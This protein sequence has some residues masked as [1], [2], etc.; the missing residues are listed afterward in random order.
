MTRPVRILIVCA[1][2]RWN[3]AVRETLENV[4]P[5]ASFETAATIEALDRALA[6]GEV[7]LVLAAEPIAGT[8]PSC[9]ARMA[10]ARPKLPIIAVTPQPEDETT[11]EAGAWDA[12]SVASGPRLRH[13]VVRAL[14]QADERRIAEAVLR[15]R[16]RS[17]QLHSD[18]QAR[19]LA[20]RDA[21]VELTANPV[22]SGEDR[23]A[24]FRLITELQARTL[25]VARASIWQHTD[26]RSAILCLDLFEAAAGRHSSGMRMPAA[27]YPAYFAALT[28]TDVIV[29][30]QARTDPD[31]AELASGYLVPLD[32]SSM[33]DAA[34]RLRGRVEGVVCCEHVGPARTWTTDEASFA[35]AVASVVSLVLE[36]G[37]RQRVER[38]LRLLDAALNA[39]ANAMVITDRAGSIVWVNPAFT[40]LTGYASGEAVGR[41]HRDMVKSGAHDPAFYEGLWKVIGAGEVWRG[42]MINRRKDGT[43]YHE[44]QTI[45]PVKDAAGTIT[46]FIAIKRDLT[47]RRQLEAQF[48]QSQKMEVIGQLAGGVA[49]D[50]NNLL[51]VIH[52][53]ARFMTGDDGVVSDAQAGHVD[54]IIKAAER[55]AQLTRQLLAFSRRQVMET[56]T[57]D[58]NELTGHLGRMLQRLIGEHIEVRVPSGGERLLVTADR[59][60]LEQVLMNLAV[61]AKDAMPNGGVLEFRSSVVEAGA[62][63]P[64]PDA[65]KAG[66][67]VAISVADTGT[68]MSEEVRARVFEPFFTT[69][70]ADRGTG[71]GLSTVYGIVTQS[72]GH[73]LV[74]SQLGSGSTFT[75]CLPRTAQPS[76]ATAPKPAATP[77]PKAHGGDEVLL[78]V[79]DEEPV[80]MLAGTLLKRAGYSIVEAT[81]PS[82][83][84][85][86]FDR[87]EGGVDLLVTDMVMPGG[88]G[89]ELFL[90]L[91]EKRPGLRVVFMSGYPEDPALESILSR[92]G[93]TFLAKPF[94]AERL[95]RTVREVLDREP[96]PPAG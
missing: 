4:R 26:D 5:G 27:D 82:E 77:Q 62:D 58:V 96:L 24:A 92:P 70:P 83:A 88:T 46:H 75:V 20:Q 8:L 48:R 80:R 13:A 14:R 7:D 18:Q 63:G 29:A 68:G 44:A 90:A 64:L 45:T 81:K 23:A 17:K 87:L 71:L 49:H 1:D 39:A 43:R 69:K 11:I 91:V 38:E 21:L 67:Y 50:F 33:L 59:G 36:T 3:T 57:F 61:N 35:L 10:V 76:D 25:G 72:G 55:A 84:T 74:S 85:Q 78:L 19:Y 94:T 22:L 2:G 32:I 6:S 34:V 12:V 54:E 40:A 9:C 47:E 42:E 52:G 28:R 65:A 37:A 15:E 30:N 93:T 51:T 66:S 31:T 53:Y 56:S 95:M 41:N 89:A 16:D 60:Q 79:E 73:V 86:V